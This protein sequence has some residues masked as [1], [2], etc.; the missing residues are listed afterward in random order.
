MNKTFSIH[1]L[2][3][4]LNFSESSEIA[5]RLRECGFEHAE[6]PDYIIVNSCAVTTVAEKKVRNL[7]AHLHRDTP[8]AQIVVV[9]CQAA[10][11]APEILQWPGVVAT[12][13]NEDKMNLLPFLQ[14][15]PTPAA[16][17]FYSA[18]S[19]NDRTRSFLKIQDGCDYH[20]TYCTVWRARGA[21]RSD[22]VE[23]VL[24][25]LRTI[26]ERGIQEVV[27]TGVNLGDFGRRNGSSFLELLRAVEAEDLGLRLRISSIEPNLLTDDIIN[28]A[29]TSRT[30]MPHFHIPLQA[31]HNRV[32]ADMH[33]RYTRELYAEKVYKVKAALP[34]ACIA[35]DIIAGFPG[36][37]DDEFADGLQFLE[38][39][40]ISYCHVFTYS[41]RPDTPAALMPQV[42]HP[43]K[44]ERTNQLI[45][46]SD[47]KKKAFYHQH[48]GEQRPVLVETEEKA[49]YM[50]GF[51]DNY[52][53]LKLPFNA[54]Q[55][56]TIQQ[57]TIVE[58]N[59]CLDP[60]EL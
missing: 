51:T 49:G 59:L 2:G 31:A 25:Q 52:I 55:T 22:T 38:N 46:L 34:H 7:V 50:F 15:Q 19:S 44:H 12:F 60:T 30:I 29:A 57:V 5:R 3:C 18:F 8:D 36:E 14:G 17:P 20:C 40:P 53:K 47:R 54:S 16:P 24:R 45:A 10:L 35:M 26:A 11:R 1:T 4:K 42:P 23:G 13:G 43:V 37:T 48:L 28:L 58:E 56:N 21:S 32:L 33:R 39:L 41:A 9:G 6:H 27:L